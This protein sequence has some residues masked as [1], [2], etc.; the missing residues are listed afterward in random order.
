[1]FKWQ[2][3]NFSKEPNYEKVREID[4]PLAFASYQCEYSARKIE[5][6]DTFFSTSSD[7]LCGPDFDQ[8]TIFLVGWVWSPLYGEDG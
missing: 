4:M 7:S 1:M 8:W 5:K 6:N 2:N 3:L